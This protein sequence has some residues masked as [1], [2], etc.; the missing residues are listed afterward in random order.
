MPK[1]TLWIERTCSQGA[2][3]SG[4]IESQ[5][6]RVGELRLHARVSTSPA[7]CQLPP[8]V[9]VHGIGI[10]SRYWVPTSVLLAPWFRNY[11]PD[12][13]GF[14]LSDKP[15]RTLKVPQLSDW[16]A[17]WMH[18]RNL[19]GAALVGNSFGCQ[20]VA[21]CAARYPE[22]VSCTV[23]IGPT[24]D[25]KGNSAREQVRRWHRNNPGEP[26]THKIVSYRDYWDCGIPRVLR[27]FE[28]SR[29][30]HIERK[31]PHIQVPSL[32]VRGSCDPIVPQRWAEE[33]TRLLPKGK[34]VV[35]PGAFHTINFS[36]P[37]ELVRVMVPFFIEVSRGL[38]KPRERA[39]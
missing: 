39:A 15:R 3:K 20:I 9:L 24:T 16:L 32:V 6:T 25:P 8:V 33:A 37:L 22:L 30:D 12:L 2:A 23:H 21:D 38:E 5:W 7:R 28:H 10:T 34:L 11:A 18:A 19:K 17:A 35:I 26:F 14:G 31:L 29:D 1:D 4:W 13:P 36:S 27:T